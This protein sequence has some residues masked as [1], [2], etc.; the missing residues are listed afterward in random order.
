VGSG[1]ERRR[2]RIRCFGGVPIHITVQSTELY[3]RPACERTI[4]GRSSWASVGSVAHITVPAE[5]FVIHRTR[6]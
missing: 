4:T 1:D 5:Y 6:L 3:G 2:I